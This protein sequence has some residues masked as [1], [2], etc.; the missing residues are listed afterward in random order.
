LKREFTALI[1]QLQSHQTKDKH[2]TFLLDEHM[3]DLSLDQN[4]N[5]NNSQNKYP[6]HNQDNFIGDIKDKRTVSGMSVMNNIKTNQNVSV[7]KKDNLL[8]SNF[9]DKEERS[10]KI[11]A[12]IKDK[13]EISIK[14]I[15]TTLTDCSEKTI[16]RELNSLISKGQIKKSGS[17]RW[18]RYHSISA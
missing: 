11:I 9:N 1:K 3:F 12:L 18:S 15:S 10:N 4:N 17:K 6:S 13:K 2:F 7:V 14:D 5:S 8:R 16:Q